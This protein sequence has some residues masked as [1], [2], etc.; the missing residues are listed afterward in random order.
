MASPLAATGPSA[1]AR[2]TYQRL[3]DRHEAAAAVLSRTGIVLA[4]NARLAALLDTAPA[5]L[6]GRP[7]T[8]FLPELHCATFRRLLRRDLRSPADLETLL[9]AGESRNRFVRLLLLQME[10]PEPCLFL[11]VM[12]IRKGRDIVRVEEQMAE[13]AALV[14]ERPADLADATARPQN[15]L[16]QRKRAEAASG[17]AA[18]FNETIIRSVGDGVIVYDRDLRYQVWNPAMEAMTGF[19]QAEVLG[20]CALDL[21][22]YLRAYGIDEILRLALAGETVQGPDIRYE[23]PATGRCGWQSGIFRPHRDAQGEIVGVVGVVR[24]ISARKAAEEALAL[25]GLL[26]ETTRDLILFIRPEDGAVLRANQAALDAYGYTAEELSR[27]TVWDLRALET[28][29]TIREDLEAAAADGVCFETV[30][31]RKDG[32]RFPVEVSAHGTTLAGIRMLLSIIRDISRRKRA[33]EALRLSEQ[34]FATAFQASPAAVALATLAE[35]RLLEVNDGLCR[36]LGYTR[37]E[38]LGRTSTE[39]GFWAD[40]ADRDALRQALAS[41]HPVQDREVR[42]VTKTGGILV[43]ALSAAVVDLGGAPALL[44]VTR[45][46][47]EEKRTEAALRESEARFRALVMASAEVVYRMSP[48]WSEMRRLVGREFLR[49]TDAPSRTWLETYIFPEDQPQV[50]AVI[51]EAI[52]TQT[53]FRLE[54]R[55]RR[56]DGTE[57][58]TFSQAIPLLDA[59]RQIVEWIGTASDITERKRAERERERLLDAVGE[60]RA[61]LQAILD[62]LPVGVWITDAAGKMVHVN[63][64]ARAIWGGKAPAAESLAGY[65]AYKAWW[66]D[67]G[68][69]IRPEEMPLARAVQGERTDERVVDF[70]RFDGTRGTQYLSAAPIRDAHGTIRGAVAIAQDITRL[71]EAEVGLRQA[72]ADKDA[73]LREVHHRVKN[74]L[75]MLCDLMFLQ[76]EAMPDRDQHQD[77]Q[78]AYSRVFAI[79]RLHEQL[80]QTMAGGRI[81]LEDYLRR[82]AGGFEDLFPTVSVVVEAAADGV[83]LDLDRAIHA[84]LIVNELVTNAIKHAVPRRHHGEVTVAITG[85]NGQIQLQVRDNG[86]GIPADLDLEQAKTLGLRTVRLLARR[87]EAEVTISRDGGTTVTL[88]F[89]IHGDVPV[90]PKP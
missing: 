47:T 10:L 11:L 52:R 51:R 59:Q 71:R 3:L 24:D 4:S 54:H 53:M 83:T 86:R 9:G 38:I 85:V 75:Q 30:H 26:A 65:D 14:R 78:D 15:E 34:K 21:F 58:W 36:L 88:T 66:A 43:G 61:R 73:L 64:E 27:R 84:G 22:P 7:F 23:V 16:T 82:L 20:K 39:L 25:Y 79:A 44:T 63:R 37:T 70:E 90:E 29:V 8:D 68:A 13:L 76:M 67:T 87:L 5:G 50:L 12:E 32:S 49:D 31:Q 62:S 56:A 2:S 72:V 81:R 19:S 89:P 6:D 35:G 17:D 77:L 48:D 40:P 55:I 41:G 80:Y 1:E 60:Q 33:E 69:P 74:N 28:H 57:G 46:V 42:F 18:A 45:D